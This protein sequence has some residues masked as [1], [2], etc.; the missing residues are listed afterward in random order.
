[1]LVKVIKSPKPGK[2]YRA[3]FDDGKT[4]DFGASGMEDYTMHKD[5]E[6]RERYLSRHRH[7]LETNDPRRAGYLSYYILWGPSTNMDINIALYK[8]RFG[9]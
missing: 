8:K 5:T 1:M 7:D 4:V 6:R 2:K 9:L 3:I